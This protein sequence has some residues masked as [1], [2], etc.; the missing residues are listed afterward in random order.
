MPDRMRSTGVRAAWCGR[1]A[2]QPAVGLLVAFVALLLAVN[3]RALV[4]LDRALAT[5]VQ[6]P[7]DCGLVQLGTASSVVFALEASVLLSALAS[8]ALWRAGYRL[9]WALVPWLMYVSLLSELSLKL[10]G[11]QPSPVQ[12]PW[13]QSVC[14]VDSGYPLPLALSS[15][16]SFPSGFS[17]RLGYFTVLAV[18]LLVAHGQRRWA[19]AAVLLAAV[20]YAWFAWSRVYIFWHWPMDVLGGVLLGAALAFLSLWLLAAQPAA[21]ARAWARFAPGGVTPT[22]RVA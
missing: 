17:I 11:N 1:G 6:A 18:G 12:V 15:P 5:W 21:L 22:R 3:A 19:T 7:Q 13:P 10:W 20:L 4:G 16:N 9:P 2:W 14:G 8:L